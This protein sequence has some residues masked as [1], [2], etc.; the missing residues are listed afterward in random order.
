MKAY[1]SVGIYLAHSAD[2]QYYQTK[3]VSRSN[4]QVGDIV[5]YTDRS[6]EIV[7]NAIYIGGGMVVHAPEPGRTVE[8]RS[9]YMLTIYGYGRP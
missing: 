9:M 2:T 8:I 4:L 3:R 7:H 6:G 1:E 5:F